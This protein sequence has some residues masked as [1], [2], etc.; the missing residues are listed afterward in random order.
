[1][2]FYEKFLNAIVDGECTEEFEV[3]LDEIEMELEG[4]PFGLDLSD[5]E[6][7]CLVFNDDVDD[8]GYYYTLLHIMERSYNDDRDAFVEAI[9]DGFAES[10]NCSEW[11]ATFL[12]RLCNG[13]HTEFVKFL[14]SELNEDKKVNFRKVNAL[15]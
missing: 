9:V 13:G 1:M 12:N 7:L 6:E 3:V 5:I 14:V 8:Y 10:T 2:K 11:A 15:N 4:S